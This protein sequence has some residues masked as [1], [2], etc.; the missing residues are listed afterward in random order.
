MEKNHVAIICNL[1][2]PQ[3]VFYY[4]TV[5]VITRI[6]NEEKCN[7]DADKSSFVLS[8]SAEIIGVAGIMYVAC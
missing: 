7:D 5:M 3:A 1:V 4:G 2:C 8:S 6:F